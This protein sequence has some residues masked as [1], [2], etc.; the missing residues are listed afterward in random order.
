MR[1]CPGSHGPEN[2]LSSRCHR[3]SS[4][5]QLQAAVSRYSDDIQDSTQADERSFTVLSFS[6]LLIVVQGPGPSASLTF[7]HVVPLHADRN[8]LYYKCQKKKLAQNLPACVCGDLNR[9][10]AFCDNNHAG[11]KNLIANLA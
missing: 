9:G 11:L 3:T 10:S 8:E 1:R 4:M 6:S 2:T 7:V 5:I